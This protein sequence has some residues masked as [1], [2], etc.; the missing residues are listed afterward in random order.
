VDSFFTHKATRARSRSQNLKIPFDLDGE[1]LESIWTGVCPVSG[2]KLSRST[3]RSD[4][5]AA[6]LD[7]LIPSRGYVRGNVTFLS[8]K[9][10]RL[11]NN[12]LLEELE[13]LIL[14][15]RKVGDS[16]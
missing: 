7:R 13:N 9:I 14:W 8:R 3:D 12:A 1:Y 15:L 16:S 5:D 4:E 6:E 10:S 2:V 11:K